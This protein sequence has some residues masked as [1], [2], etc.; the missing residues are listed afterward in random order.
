MNEYIEE[1]A[2][3][4]GTS[5]AMGDHGCLTFWIYLEGRGWGCG[6]GGYAIAH[7]FLDAEPDEFE[8]KSGKGLEAMMQA[9]N[10][11][12]VEKWEDL[13]GKYCRCRLEGLGGGVAAIGHIIS[14]KWFNIREFYEKKDGEQ[15]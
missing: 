14:D 15:N 6:F 8:A 9:M 5:I 1:N 10:A 11:V 4:T 12:G 2:K 3:I 7:G 13:K